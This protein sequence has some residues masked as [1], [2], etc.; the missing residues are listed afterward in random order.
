MLSSRPLSSTGITLLLQYYG[1]VRLPSGT[2]RWLLI[3][4]GSSY[5][6]GSPSHL[7]QPFRARCPQTP[8]RAQRLLLPVSSPPVSGFLLLRLIGHPHFESRGRIGSLSLRLTRSL[9]IRQTVRLPPP[10]P[11]CDSLPG[12]RAI[13]KVGTSQPTRLIRRCWLP[14]A[15]MPPRISKDCILDAQSFTSLCISPYCLNRSESAGAQA[16]SQFQSRNSF[17]CRISNTAPAKWT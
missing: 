17:D 2:H 9:L 1:P 10:C 4:T 8:R 6:D 15:R 3:P 14:K 7:Y 5:P 16:A 12:E 11:A 13:T